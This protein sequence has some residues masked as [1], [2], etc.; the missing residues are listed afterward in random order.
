MCEALG[1]VTPDRPLT[2]TVQGDLPLAAGLGSSAALAVALVRAA[3]ALEGRVRGP[4]EVRARAHVLEQ[5]AHGRASGIDDA[6]VAWE[7]PAVFQPLGPGSPGLS[8]G[9][10]P[11]SSGRAALARLPQDTPRPPFWVAW[12]AR[13]RSTRE[14]VFEVASRRAEQPARFDRARA[15]AAETV[16]AAL[17]ALLRGDWR[18]LGPVLAKAHEALD[19]IGVV[20]ETHRAMVAAACAAGAW[21]A[22]TTGAGCGGAIL[23]L[24]PPTLDLSSLLSIPGVEGCFLAGG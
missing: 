6:V 19:D 11:G 21:G 12:T 15:S 5:L 17:S 10:A 7:R 22:K 13:E 24:G 20:T 4:A 3:D 2:V 23:I 8:S 14:A 9:S 1:L 16:E 18:A